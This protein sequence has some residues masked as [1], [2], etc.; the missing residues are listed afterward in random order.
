MP[1]QIIFG[2]HDMPGAA[3]AVPSVETELKNAVASVTLQTDA[4]RTDFS[5]VVGD[6][7]VGP[8]MYW[9]V[10]IPTGGSTSPVFDIHSH[11]VGTP[12]PYHS[13]I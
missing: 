3:T 1:M 9:P 6:L 13:S 4:V 5:A 7:K 10:T 2:T 8:S 12:V 11:P